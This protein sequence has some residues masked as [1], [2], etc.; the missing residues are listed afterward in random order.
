MCRFSYSLSVSGEAAGVVSIARIERPQLHRGCS[1]STETVSAVSPL[2][3][4]VCSFLSSEGCLVEPQL[5]AANESLLFSLLPY[6]KEEGRWSLPVRIEGPPFHRGASASR[7]D[8]LTTPFSSPS[9]PISLH[10]GGLAWSPTAHVERPQFHRG[11]SVSKGDQPGR[12]H[13]LLLANASSPSASARAFQS[14][15]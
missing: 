4:Q 8:H 12:P 15:L 5:H 14:R 2:P 10:E 3:F 1:A 13:F 7:K 9:S 6:L 11:G